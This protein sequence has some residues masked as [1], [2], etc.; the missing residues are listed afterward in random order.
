MRRCKVVVLVVAL[1]VGLA[2]TLASL[3]GCGSSTST[4][5]AVKTYSSSQYGFSLQYDPRFSENNGASAQSGPA[6]ASAAFNMGFLDEKG[7]IA[8]KKY[9]DGMLIAVYQLKQSIALEQ[10]PQLKSQLEALMPQLKAGLQDATLSALES[11]TVN[12]TP[13]FK[14]D[15]TYTSG[16]TGLQATTYFLIKGDKEYQLTIQGAAD[17]WS[18]LQPL[19][20]KTV[21]SFTV[22]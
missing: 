2:V 9:V 7:T 5:T 22:Q 12:G 4:K 8:D 14:L 18:Q 3:A 10:V 17:K 1:A 15:Y 20:A 6:G 13:G 16:G 11:T 19:M 21:D